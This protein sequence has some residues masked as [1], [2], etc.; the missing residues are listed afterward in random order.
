MQICHEYI[1]NVMLTKIPDLASVSRV[2]NLV[3]H[4]YHDEFIVVDSTYIVHK[5][6]HV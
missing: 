2:L 1:F 6:N 3:C 4:H 5:E